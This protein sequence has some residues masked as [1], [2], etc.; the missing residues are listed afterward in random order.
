[1]PCA[2]WRCCGAT[3]AGERGAQLRYP[4]LTFRRCH[5]SEDTKS[6]Q[7]ALEK[8]KRAVETS[9]QGGVLELGLKG[10]SQALIEIASRDSIKARQGSAEKPRQPPRLT[11]HPARRRATWPVRESRRR[12]C[13]SRANPASQCS[14]CARTILWRT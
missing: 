4:A 5:R 3:P 12:R 8:Y 14:S 6:L 1:M 10:F 2:P 7:A 11:P 9:V 13:A